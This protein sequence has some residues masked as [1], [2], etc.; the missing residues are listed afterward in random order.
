LGI[1]LSEGHDFSSNWTADTNKCYPN[2]AAVK[3]IGLKSPINQLISWDGN[4]TQVRI[5][6]IVK[7]AL[8]ESPFKSIA[9]AI[10]THGQSGTNI[11]YRMSDKANTKMPLLHLQKYLMTMIISPLQLSLRR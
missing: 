9:P 2:E 5:I 3:R 10:F 1:R 7:D 11:I 4:L 8:M 6:G